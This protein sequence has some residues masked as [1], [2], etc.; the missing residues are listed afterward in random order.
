MS[1]YRELPPVDFDDYVSLGVGVT[2]IEENVPAPVLPRECSECS[3]ELS[4]TYRVTIPSICS[5]CLQT[6]SMPSGAQVVRNTRDMSEFVKSSPP[7]YRWDLTT[8]SHIPDRTIRV[9]D[10][11][12]EH[13]APPTSN[14]PGDVY[15]VTV[16]GG[17]SGGTYAKGGRS[18]GGSSYVYSPTQEDPRNWS[19]TQISRYLQEHYGPY[20]LRTRYSE[21]RNELLYGIPGTYPFYDDPKPET[22]DPSIHYPKSHLTGREE[23]A[24]L[25]ENALNPD[26]E[27]TD[28]PME[29][30]LSRDEADAAYKQA[31]AALA[32]LDEVER[33]YSP[34]LP[35][36]SVIAF[37]L[38][39]PSRPGQYSYAAVKAAGLWFA[40]GK[41]H[42]SYTVGTGIA[43]TTLLSGLEQFQAT[44]FEVLRTGGEAQEIEAARTV[45]LP[46]GAVTTAFDG[47]DDDDDDDDEDASS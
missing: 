11:Y 16:G 38:T 34:D 17:G 31:A 46:P 3:K 7:G 47:P 43:W 12:H 14:K 37:N 10:G 1:D 33:K 36:G 13:V 40:T 8:Q 29:H 27:E 42:P 15:T 32:R 45:V 21:L 35:N 28:M 25:N 39:F 44:N 30:I 23:S 26:T 20:E 5:H 2:D 4:Y 41:V 9:T 18:G 22:E 19:P 24:I 6:H